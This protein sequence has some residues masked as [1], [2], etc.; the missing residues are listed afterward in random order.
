MIRWKKD[1]GNREE[2]KETQLFTPTE[3]KKGLQAYRLQLKFVRDFST[4]ENKALSAKKGFIYTP[5]PE[6]W[7]YSENYTDGKKVSRM[8][9]NIFQDGFG[10]EIREQIKKSVCAYYEKRETS[11][12]LESGFIQTCMLMRQIRT[13]MGQT[14][15]MCAEDNLQIAGQV[16][17]MYA[18]ENQRMARR[19]NYAKGCAVNGKWK[20]KEKNWCYYDAVY[21]YICEETGTI[22]YEATS[23][24]ARNWEIPMPDIEAVEKTSK[25]DLRKGNGFNRSWNALYPNQISR[26]YMRD[27]SRM[28]PP[29]FKL[30]YKEYNPY[31]RKGILIAGGEGSIKKADVPFIY[32][33]GNPREQIYNASDLLRFLPEET[34]DFAAYNEY[35][36]N[37]SIFS[38]SY[39]CEDW[40]EM[41]I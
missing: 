30:F 22:I 18:K 8:P 28:P 4:E 39:I 27:E 15:G 36:E 20:G 35:L 33:L 38:R 5:A 31:T 32:F 9:G 34:A 7:I 6:R 25:I 11:G 19:A 21:Y 10:Y 12:E 41:S 3:L 23:R 17:E 37:F 14:T 13:E 24:I 40:Q 16:Y 1:W 2:G 29:D 26:V